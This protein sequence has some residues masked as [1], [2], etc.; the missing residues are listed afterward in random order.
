MQLAFSVLGGSKSD[1]LAEILPAVSECL[2]NIVE[3]RFSQLDYSNAAYLL[4]EGNWNEVAKLETMLDNINKRPDIFI[5]SMRPEDTFE[6]D[7]YVPYSLETI[8][9]DRINLVQCI[10]TFLI[11]RNMIINE[12][13]GS[14]YRTSYIDTPVFSTKFIIF[15]PPGLRLLSLREEFLDFCDQL[16]ID[17]ILEPIKR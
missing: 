5:N 9:S 14:R 2:C 7:D 10:S 15:V 16:N 1:I 17:A 3:I 4:I 8:C 12:I 11:E 13:S 6:D